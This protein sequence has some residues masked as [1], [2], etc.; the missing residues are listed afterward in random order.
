MAN[1]DTDFTTGD[2]L[3]RNVFCILGMP[4]DVEDMRSVL[5]KI[6]KAVANRAPFFI[7]TPNLNHLVN[8]QSDNEFRESLYQSDLCPVDGMPIVWIARILSAPIKSRIAGSDIFD[9]LKAEHDFAKPLKIFLFGGLEGVASLACQALNARPSGLCCVGSL[10][11]GFGSVD[12]MSGDDIVAKIN[13]SDA[14]FLVVSLGAQKGQLWL[15]RNHDR[16]RIPVRAHLG[17]VMNFQAATVRRAPVV[18]RRLGLEWLWRIKEEP[19][20]WRRYWSDGRVLLRL[21]LT[22]VL[23]LA[24]WTRWV[25]LAYRLHGQGLIIRQVRDDKSITVSLSGAAI[26][27]HVEKVIATFRDVLRTKK[28]IVV[29]FTHVRAIDARF[30]GLLLMLRK[31]LKGDSSS[32]SFVGLSPAIERIFRL[33]G[34]GFL[35]TEMCL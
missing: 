15:L 3:S 31:K 16:L 12:D 18:F 14:D 20:L 30:F 7:T 22:R 19:Y 28:P 35:L 6:R 13:S 1:L 17:A 34:L 5:Y 32:V 2:D 23:P 25:R 29:D 21:F 33:N 9:A 24:I 11:P 26:A 8:M 27:G 4:I 10:Y